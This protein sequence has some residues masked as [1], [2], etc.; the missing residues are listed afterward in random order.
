[1]YKAF[2]SKESKTRCLQQV[3]FELLIAASFLCFGDSLQ[4]TA[5]TIQLH[6]YYHCDLDSQ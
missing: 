6:V 3:V 2:C 4:A 1:M 5:S